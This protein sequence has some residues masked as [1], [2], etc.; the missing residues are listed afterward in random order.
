MKR[1]NVDSKKSG[2][3]TNRTERVKTDGREG[4]GLVE[5][6]ENSEDGGREEHD[7]EQAVVQKLLG[8]VPIIH[9]DIP[10]RRWWDVLVTCLVL[11]TVIDTP[12][13]LAYHVPLISTAVTIV[14]DLLFIM[15]IFLQFCTGFEEEDSPLVIM[16][17]DLIVS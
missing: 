8:C 5:E 9:P 15:D 1:L 11:F 12:W 2:S 4:L 14:V 10:A 3:Q 7:F 17:P 16:E 13:K 6:N